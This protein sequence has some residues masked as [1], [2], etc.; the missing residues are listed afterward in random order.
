MDDYAANPANPKFR[1]QIINRLRKNNIFSID[2]FRIQS[3]LYKALLKK[4]GNDTTMLWVGT[5]EEYN[6]ILDSDWIL[7]Q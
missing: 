6:K 4:V 7:K 5:H 2:L 1:M 3:T